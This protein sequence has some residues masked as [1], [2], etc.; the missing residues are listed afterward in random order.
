MKDKIKSLIESIVPNAFVIVEDRN[1]LGTKS[2]KIL[3]AAS[4]KLI[5]GVAGQYPG[6]VSLSLHVKTMELECQSF[7]GCGGKCLLVKP[8]LNN[9]KE[10]HHAFGSIIVP[11][12][13]PK[14]DERNVLSAI[15]LFIRRWQKT[16][17]KN[18]RRMPDYGFDWFNAVY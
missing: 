13:K 12:R 11:F 9:P 17:L 6:A 10:A 5:N 8:D 15:E 2:L 18:L 4:D 1:F 3:V 7:G 16:I 14:T